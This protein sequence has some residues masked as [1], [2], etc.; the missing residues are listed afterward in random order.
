MRIEISSS[1][2]PT[3]TFNGVNETIDFDSENDDWAVMEPGLNLVSF[4][5]T[6]RGG[7]DMNQ[8]G[9]T[10]TYCTV[11][12]DIENGLNASDVNPTFANP[13]DAAR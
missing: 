9:N 6:K 11:T 1:A 10:P 5:E 4:T 12:F 2:A 7:S 8:G 3:F 13:S